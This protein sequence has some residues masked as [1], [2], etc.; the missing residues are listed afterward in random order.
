MGIHYGVV[1][2]VSFE[3]P[4]TNNDTTVIIGILQDVTDRILNQTVDND[5]VQS[6]DYNIQTHQMK[7]ITLVN[8]TIFV[9]DVQ[10][11]SIVLIAISNDTLK[12]DLIES[13]NDNTHLVVSADIISIQTDTITLESAIVQSTEITT[14]DDALEESEEMEENNLIIYILG[15]VILCLAMSIISLFCFWKW[16]SEQ[17]RQMIIVKQASHGNELEADTSMIQDIVPKIDTTRK[18]TEL[19]YI[20]DANRTP[21]NDHDEKDNDMDVNTTMDEMHENSVDGMYRIDNDTDGVIH[22][23]GTPTAIDDESKINIK[24]ANDN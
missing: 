14:T 12:Q 24:G 13:I 22:T 1:I 16:R 18:D 8:A 20:N 15:I 10:S 19:M 3:Y 6:K 23:M 7:N 21:D 17:K 2:T 4:L 11:Q 5:C 9:C